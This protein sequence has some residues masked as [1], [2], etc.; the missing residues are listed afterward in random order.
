MKH[1]SGSTETLQ[2]TNEVV[3]PSKKP[4]GFFN[5]HATKISLLMITSSL[6]FTAHNLTKYNDSYDKVFGP[7]DPVDE[8][9]VQE[10]TNEIKTIYDDT[11]QFKENRD[12]LMSDLMDVIDHDGLQVTISDDTSESDFITASINRSIRYL[13]AQYIDASGVKE[14]VVT[15]LNKGIEA[16]RSAV[17]IQ[18][19]FHNPVS[20]EKIYIDTN[21]VIEGDRGDITRTLS[22][23]IGHAAMLKLCGGYNPPEQFTDANPSDFEYGNPANE[24]HIEASRY[25]EKNEREAIVEMM[26]SVTDILGSDNKYQ[27]ANRLAKGDPIAERKVAVTAALLDKLSPGLGKTT[28]LYMRFD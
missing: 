6:A 15:D 26:S 28:M 1:F 2:T 22:H 17:W 20:S 13:P 23:E 10:Y 21:Y 9:T 19:G 5:R 18:R 3:T 12:E 24:G 27:L 11:L 16:D 8:A 14:V 25:G 4:E 7:C